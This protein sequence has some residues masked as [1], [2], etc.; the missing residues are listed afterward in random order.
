[1]AC[2]EARG[3][4]VDWLL[5]RTRA[6]RYMLLIIIITIGTSLFIE[7]CTHSLSPLRIC[8]GLSPVN[9]MPR[10]RSAARHSAS[11]MSVDAFPQDVLVV[12]L[13]PVAAAHRR[14]VALMRKRRSGSGPKAARPMNWQNAISCGRWSASSV[15]ESLNRDIAWVSSSGLS[16]TPPSRSFHSRSRRR[17]F[18]SASASFADFFGGAS[19]P[20]A[21]RHRRR[22]LGELLALLGASLALQLEGTL[23]QRAHHHLGDLE[24]HLQQILPFL[25]DLMLLLEGRRQQVGEEPQRERQRKL[26][27]R[28]HQEE[29]ERDDPSEVRQHAD[30]QVVLPAGAE[31]LAARELADEAPR[32]LAARVSAISSFV[33]W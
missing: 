2:T 18:S 9:G 10:A 21:R 19:P 14:S 12:L 20:S 23:L 31:R 24:A 6:K 29:G 1:M 16:A 4:M 13:Q 8:S 22:R 28:H 11:V 30:E 25:F 17:F 15:N 27:E 32:D 26:H 7:S 33:P 5:V 3:W